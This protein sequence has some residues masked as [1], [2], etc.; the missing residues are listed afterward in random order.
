MKLT[1]G[2]LKQIS[3]SDC[4]MKPFDKWGYTPMGNVKKEP[5]LAMTHVVVA[6]E[7]C[8]ESTK[9]LL[10]NGSEITIVITL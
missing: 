4:Y 5:Y 8:W 3:N 7:I 9:K 6:S 1:Q 2:D 10:E